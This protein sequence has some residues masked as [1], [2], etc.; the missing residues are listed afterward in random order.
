MRVQ[1]EEPINSHRTQRT[2]GR[3]IFRPI[4]TLPFSDPISCG[5]LFGTQKHPDARISSFVET[6][7]KPNQL[8]DESG[9]RLFIRV[10]IR[11]SQQVLGFARGAPCSPLGPREMGNR[12]VDIAINVR[13]NANLGT[14]SFE[15]SRLRDRL[16]RMRPVQS[17]FRPV[18]RTHQ[19]CI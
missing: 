19:C 8:I 14:P 12:S 11:E 1:P 13:G 2:Y 5:F 17:R 10:E 18:A 3:R 9:T 15:T 6:L 16:R 4:F 7:G